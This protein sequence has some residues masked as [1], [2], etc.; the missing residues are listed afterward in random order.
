VTTTWSVVYERT[1]TGWSGYVPAL[2]GLAV[3]GA[4]RDNR[5]LLYARF[6][7]MQAAEHGSFRAT[8]RERRKGLEGGTY[9]FLPK[10][11]TSQRV[12]S[13]ARGPSP[14]ISAPDPLRAVCAKCGID[15]QARG[16]YVECGRQ[17]RL[18]YTEEGAR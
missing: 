6:P 9:L 10:P 15:L 14:R 7:T 16:S 5:A 11:F 4:T 18:L 3:S 1:V 2:P 12:S 13:P 8:A 17:K